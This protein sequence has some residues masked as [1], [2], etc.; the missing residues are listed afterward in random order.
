MLGKKTTPGAKRII[1]RIMEGHNML[2]SFML[3]S[4]LNMAYGALMGHCQYRRLYLDPKIKE[5]KR[6]LCC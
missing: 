5:E 1:C 2:G 3:R 4:E 6:K